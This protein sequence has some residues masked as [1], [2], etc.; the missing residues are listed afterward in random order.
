MNAQVFAEWL[1]QQGHRI[2]RTEN[3]SWYDAGPRVFQA[4]PYHQVIRPPEEELAAF[5]RRQG[6]IALRY[7]TPLDA[8]VGR[9]S[10]HVVCENRAYDMPALERR[11][12]QGVR[13]GLERCR[14][15]AI[16][17]D[18]LAREGWQLVAETCQRQGRE[19]PYSEEAWRRRCRVAASLPGFEAWG[20]LVDGRLVASLLAVQIDDCCELLMQQCQT[21]FLEAHVNNALA[22]A[23]TREVSRRPHVNSIFYTL[24]S[25]D[26]PASVDVFKFRMGYVARPLRQRVLFHPWLAPALGRWTE[27]L[28]HRAAE[29]YPHRAL[30]KADGMIRFCREGKR[31]A[32]EQAWPECLARSRGHGAAALPASRATP[33]TAPAGRV[34]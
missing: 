24:Q 19:V 32:P 8:P 15:E 6:A 16:P 1:R 2:I 11:A 28:V 20:A 10:Y 4:F 21:A 34:P 26:A 17:L 23:V 13:H 27:L 5:L 31:P 33:A 3:A 29:R 25:L 22:F 9:V 12:R 30:T 18:R 7:S 14:V